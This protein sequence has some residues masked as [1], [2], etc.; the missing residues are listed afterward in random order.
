M[1]VALIQHTPEP[2]LT[3]ATAARLCYAPI[4]ATEIRQNISIDRARAL[5]AQVISSGHHSVLEHASFT[6]AI[7]GISRTASHQLVRHR[8]ASYSQQSQ[9]YVTFQNPDYIIPPSIKANKALEEAYHQAVMDIFQAYRHMVEAGI[10]A[11]DARF[12]LPNASA[13]R[14]VMT[15]NF[16][17]LMHAC[18]IRLCTN[19]QWE[20]RELFRLAREEVHT[21]A[22]FL[23]G[24]LLIKCETMGYCNER[25]SCG[26]RPLRS[27]I[28]GL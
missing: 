3:I 13:T 24:H 21:V 19:A 2:E 25:Q 22:P 1:K 18:S 27:D 7:D 23:A 28:P 20:I 12:L 26:I 15:M 10:P 4:S 6:F 14:L 17:E 11:E 9:R 16:R 8:M 5:L